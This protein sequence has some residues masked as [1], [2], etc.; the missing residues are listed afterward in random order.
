LIWFGKGI[1]KQEVFR[2]IVIADIS[3]TLTHLL[4]LQRAG[5]MTG[6]P[7]LEVLGN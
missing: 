3:A 6:E 5:A 2:K 7:I 1:P 4:F